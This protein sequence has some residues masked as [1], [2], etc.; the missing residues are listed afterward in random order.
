MCKNVYVFIFSEPKVGL[1][2]ERGVNG[3]D[4]QPPYRHQVNMHAFRVEHIKTY[5]FIVTPQQ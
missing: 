4:R 2:G 3:Y 1:N 5:T